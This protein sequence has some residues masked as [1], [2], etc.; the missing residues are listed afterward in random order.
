[1]QSKTKLRNHQVLNSYFFKIKLLAKFED[2]KNQCN[3]LKTGKESKYSIREKKN[4][5]FSI[6]AETFGNQVISE[7]TFS[8]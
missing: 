5:F 1:M 4:L 6:Q 7:L 2:A 8:F 3:L